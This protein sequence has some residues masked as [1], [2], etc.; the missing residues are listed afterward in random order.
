MCVECVFRFSASISLP[1]E[2]RHYLP[3]LEV[4][5][6]SSYTRFIVQYTWTDVCCLLWITKIMVIAIH[7]T[8]LNAHKQIGSEHGGGLDCKHWTRL[9]HTTKRSANISGSLLGGAEVPCEGCL[10]R[11]EDT[12]WDMQQGHLHRCTNLCKDSPV[13][14]ESELDVDLFRTWWH[15]TWSH[16][17]YSSP[18]YWNNPGVQ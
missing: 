16:L 3:H 8:D 7:T 11:Q 1:K 6:C 18:Y 5:I 13:R 17:Y 14:V 10:P 4:P 15:K 2:S 9:L 12:D